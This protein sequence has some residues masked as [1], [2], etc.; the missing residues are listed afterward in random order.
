MLLSERNIENVI[1]HFTTLSH[2]S[3]E[4]YNNAWLLWQKDWNFVIYALEILIKF[5]I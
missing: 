5:F 3:Q 1:R 4:M 2:T